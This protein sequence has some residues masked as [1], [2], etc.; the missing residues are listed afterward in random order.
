MLFDDPS[1]KTVFL[2][3]LHLES[4]VWLQIIL[5]LDNW[6]SKKS[7]DAPP[8]LEAPPLNAPK[9]Y[10]RRK[11][12][13]R[14]LSKERVL[15]VLTVDKN[16]PG[17]SSVPASK[18]TKAVDNDQHLPGSLSGDDGEN[19][20]D[21]APGDTM[22]RGPGSAQF[23]RRLG[24]RTRKTASHRDLVSA[25]PGRQELGFGQEEVITT[26]KIV[27][28]PSRKFVIASEKEV[29]TSLE[30]TQEKS[31]SIPTRQKTKLLKDTLTQHEQTP[32]TLEV[33]SHSEDQRKLRSSEKMRSDPESSAVGVRATARLSKS[34]A[35]LK[36]KSKSVTRNAAVLGTPKTTTEP[37]NGDL[38]LVSHSESPSYRK[39]KVSVDR[40][41]SKINS[42]R[43]GKVK[44]V[45]KK[46]SSISE[47]QDGVAPLHTS[48]LRAKKKG[49]TQ[50][51][52]SISTASETN[53]VQKLAALDDFNDAAV[54]L[55]RLHSTEPLRNSESSAG[56]PSVDEPNEL[57]H[58]SDVVTSSNNAALNSR[59]RRISFLGR[60]AG[61]SVEELKRV[62]LGLN[63]QRE[64]I[65]QLNSMTT[66]GR[67]D[68]NGSSRL[69]AKVGGAAASL[70]HQNG[71]NGHVGLIRQGGNQLKLQ[72][73]LYGSHIRNHVDVAAM[74]R[75]KLEE[76]GGLTEWLIGGGLGVFVDLFQERKIEEG[77][78]LNLTMGSL[79]EFGV[80]AVGPRRKL[81]WMIEHLM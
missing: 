2:R 55:G 31:S 52:R 68:A 75:S 59:S 17:S 6:D 62:N 34:M 1:S 53:S 24:L 42:S 25:K 48:V 12:D 56:V 61:T 43:V 14:I 71:A 22:A 11:S 38:E 46:S 67:A 78:L 27:I 4:F 28:N 70:N 74:V 54:A 50:P 65:S 76:V 33:T 49:L 7:T 23:S 45:Q 51:G 32:V 35:E 77:D 80:H 58:G 79:K 69:K 13:S 44:S 5:K 37:R 41:S 21:L 60:Q 26:R 9:S 57:H 8:P 29:D 63:A 73:H 16:L 72:S 20:N 39:G 3:L 47:K 18:K 40:P 64:S 66:S 15:S 10:Q 30:K 19:S 81:I 36:G